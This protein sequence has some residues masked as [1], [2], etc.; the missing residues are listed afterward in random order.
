[1]NMNPVEFAINELLAANKSKNK[2]TIEI[3]IEDLEFLYKRA[4][5]LL[6]ISIQHAYAS[7]AIAQK[8]NN[9]DRNF[10]NKFY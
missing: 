6:K 10:F 3:D 2:K 9:L 5:T 1:M 7:G 4:T 8:N